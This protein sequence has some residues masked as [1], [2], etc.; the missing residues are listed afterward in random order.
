MKTQKIIS[1][2]EAVKEQRLIQKKNL[3][4]QSRVE[5]RSRSYAEALRD[6]QEQYDIVCELVR[7]TPGTMRRALDNPRVASAEEIHEAAALATAL[8]DEFK[9]LA[10]ALKELSRFPQ[11]ALPPKEK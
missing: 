7:K 6:A 9:Q 4:G 5:N 1:A 11:N 10:F 2:P 8:S 3:L